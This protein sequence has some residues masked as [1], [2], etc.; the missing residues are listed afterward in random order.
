LSSKGAAQRHVI[1]HFQGSH[2]DDV[3]FS[4]PGPGFQPSRIAH[5]LPR[6]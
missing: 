3:A 1:V 4:V 5:P 2:V 6:F